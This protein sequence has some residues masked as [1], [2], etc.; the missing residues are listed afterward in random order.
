MSASVSPGKR[1]WVAFAA[2]QVMRWHTKGHTSRP[3]DVAQHSHGVAMWIALL[4]P[5][6]SVALLKAAIMHDLPEVRTG[7]V[8]RY[9][10]AATPEIRGILD[11]TEAAMALQYGYQTEEGL[12]DDEVKWL[13]A[14]DLFDAWLFLM[15]NIICNNEMVRQDFTR[16][17]RELKEG[18]A[19]GRYP[20]L[21]AE[22]MAQILSMHP[23]IRTW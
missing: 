5:E 16:A 4:H 7:D 19:A 13:H 6:P 3:Q 18:A 14:C 9:V 11:K 17:G 8:P 15:Q 12:T 22:A 21:P 2:G 10:K 1:V 23:W 20:A